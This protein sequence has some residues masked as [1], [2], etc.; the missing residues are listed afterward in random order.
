[1]PGRIVGLTKDTDEKRA[2]TLTLSTREQHIRR[3]RATSNICSNETLIALM[4]AIHMSLLGP[5][6]LERLAL[7]V[8]ANTE[9]TKVSIS[10]IE[11]IEL[12]DTNSSNFREFRIKLPDKASSALSFLD[13]HG[14]IAGLDLGIWW[15]SL[16]CYLL[17][18]VDERT[19][20]SDIQLLHDGLSLWLKEVLK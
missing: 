17:I 10:S 18:G 1:M 7:R 9:L 2:F 11:G 16:D 14:V 20:K 15:D 4:G 19:S 5:E 3:H 12:V 8:A 13:D 6:G